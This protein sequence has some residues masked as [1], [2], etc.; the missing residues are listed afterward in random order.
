MGNTKKE[1]DTHNTNNTF[2]MKYDDWLIIHTRCLR[3]RSEDVAL[4][5]TLR[6]VVFRQMLEPPMWDG[7]NTI[8]EGRP[9]VGAQHRLKDLGFKMRHF[10]CEEKKFFE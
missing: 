2:C 5:Q 1:F 3:H 7:K 4:L 10:S 6:S 8:I 9:M